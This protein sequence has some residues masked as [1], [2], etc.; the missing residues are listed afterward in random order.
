MRQ[1]TTLCAAE[2]KLL[3]SLFEKLRGGERVDVLLRNP[4]F[5]LLSKKVLGMRQRLEAHELSGSIQ[6]RDAPRE[7]SAS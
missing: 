4:A 1:G 7:E 5:A 3:H 2:V 6:L